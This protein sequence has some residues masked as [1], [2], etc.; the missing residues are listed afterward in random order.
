MID[1]VAL[2]G[3][4]FCKHGAVERAELPG[5]AEHGTGCDG[6]D[7]IVLADRARDDDVTV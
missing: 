4:F 6:H 5:G 2:S 1:L 3:E 7:P